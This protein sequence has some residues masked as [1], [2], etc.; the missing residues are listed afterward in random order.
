LRLRP[1]LA[2]P[3]W[4]G[5]AFFAAA[6][7]MVLGWAASYPVTGY[8]QVA[9][10]CWLGLW[11]AC[12]AL[13]G[14]VSTAR[15]PA[16]HALAAAALVALISAP[17]WLALSWGSD[18]GSLANLVAYRQAVGPPDLVRD[19]AVS[20]YF[21]W[22]A[23]IVLARL[24]ADLAGGD[25]YTGAQLALL[26]AALAVGPGLWAL[27]ERHG[28]GF[29]GLAAYWAGSYWLLNWQAVPYVLGLALLLALLALLDQR[30]PAGRLLLL[31]LL[32]AGLETHPLVGAWLALI[33]GLRLLLRLC[34]DRPA[35]PTRSLLL[36]IVVAQGALLVYKNARFLIYIVDSLRGRYAA[37]AVTGTSSRTLAI[38]VRGA[39]TFVAEDPAATALKAL[40]WLA[41]AAAA[42][43]CAVAVIAAL[44]RRRCDRLALAVTGAGALHFALG[45]AWAALGPRA[46]QLLGVLPAWCVADAA[47]EQGRTG[48]AVRLLC[49]LALVLLPAVLMRAHLTGTNFIA[50]ADRLLGRSLP[51]IEPREPLN[52]LLETTGGLPPASRLV[53]LSAR[54]IRNGDQGGCRGP[55]LVV[56]TAGWHRE[57]ALLAQHP[58]AVESASVLYDNGPIRLRYLPDCAVLGIR[59]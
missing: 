43:A 50:P 35:G 41:L 33:V 17:H 26:I 37:L 24:L 44:S 18:A 25:P 40:S 31:L 16:A 54:Q 4:W 27:L 6:A 46:V 5:A 21:Q 15:P 39:V 56:E 13:A 59:E 57:I 45:M 14:L 51:A 47:A 30:S 3:T 38:H 55:S 23:A 10:T 34:R 53:P 2:D 42:A 9:P 58:T 36:L 1:A 19:V 52:L 29:W 20:S 22:P 7:L 28:G 12:A 32:A 48:R 8:T 49:T 11:L